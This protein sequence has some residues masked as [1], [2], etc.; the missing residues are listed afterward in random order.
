MIKKPVL[1]TILFLLIKTF[2]GTLSAI[3]P[4]SPWILGSIQ[5]ESSS[6]N[7]TAP[8]YYE[9]NSI[10]TS[11]DKRKIHLDF[12]IPRSRSQQTYY[13]LVTEQIFPI[14]KKS[15]TGEPIIN[16]IEYLK[17]PKDNDYRLFQLQVQSELVTNARGKDERIYYWQVL[18]MVLPETGQIPSQT[19]IFLGLPDLIS[20]F[21]SGGSLL[22]WP[23]MYM[24]TPAKND[25]SSADRLTKIHLS[26][27]DLNTIHIPIKRT[28]EYITDHKKIIIAF[29][30]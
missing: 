7:H 10:K 30:S 23:T 24:Q 22:A 9:G 14:T 5:Y 4:T 16:T 2:Y 8:L 17:V 20:S 12:E 3:A 25:Q 28:V 29:S 6:G 27:L 1:Y 21:E 15:I 19:L 18:E 11:S 26:V 13:V